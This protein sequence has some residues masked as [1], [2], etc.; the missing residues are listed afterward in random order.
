MIGKKKSIATT[1]LKILV[2]KNEQYNKKENYAQ[3]TV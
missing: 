1:K 2:R 3:T